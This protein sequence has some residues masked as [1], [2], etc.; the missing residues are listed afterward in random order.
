[1]GTYIIIGGDGKEYGPISAADVRQWIA[2]GRL[3]AQSLAKS[4]ADAEFRPLE[5]FPEFADVWTSGTPSNISPVPSSVEIN[6]DYEIDIGGCISQ[7]WELTKKHFGILFASVL[8]MLVI[9]FA[10]SSIINVV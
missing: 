3:S 5:K 1:M 9:R 10:Y 4:V 7:G 8:L 6:A 2:E